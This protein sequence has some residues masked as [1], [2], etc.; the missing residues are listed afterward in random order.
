MSEEE[1]FRA[2]EAKKIGAARRELKILKGEVPRTR[3][4]YLEGLLLECQGDLTEA[5]KKFDMAL[6]LHLS[7]HCIWF[8]KAKV[9]E[10]LGRVDMAKRAVER[11]IKLSPGD[12]EVHL[13]YGKILYSMN[14]YP[15]ARDEVER[16][17]Q[18]QGRSAEAL[19]LYGILISIIDQD[20]VKALSYY[21]NA[22]DID[23]KLSNAWTNRG[24]ALKQI[25]DRDGSLYS[26]QKALILNPDDITA[27]KMLIK[28]D[29]KNVMRSVLDRSQIDDDEPI[30]DDE[31]EELE[32]LEDLDEEE[33]DDWD[34]ESV[35]GKP[36]SRDLPL[37]SGRVRRK[38]KTEMRDRS[39]QGEESMQEEISDRLDE[40]EE[41]VDWNG[42][43]HEDGVSE[44][45]GDDDS[46]GELVVLDCPDCGVTFTV[47]VEG[48]TKFSCPGCGLKGVID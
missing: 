41:E 21:D 7:D 13:L 12:P 48:R 47:K 29:A 3:H 10:E 36:R 37:E 11:A 15:D 30:I 8:A 17:L 6:V 9:L 16:S 44:I 18:I 5:L 14:R 19:T 42:S 24:I 33:L 4:L 26:F 23:D 38:K 40:E 2:L 35:P 1:F 32:E 22:I 46:E 28:M 25:G 45:G 31:E 39:E 43:D 27:K 20:F 34:V